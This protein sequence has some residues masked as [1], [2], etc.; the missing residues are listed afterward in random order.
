MATRGSERLLLQEAEGQSS[1][2]QHKSRSWTC[3]MD[4]VLEAFVLYCPAV[5]TFMCVVLALNKAQSDCQTS[6]D[7]KES[8]VQA[9]LARRQGLPL[10]YAD[11]QSKRDEDR[12]DGRLPE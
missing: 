1:H 9:P 10:I 11:I 6:P 12:V 4:T 3:S 2:K 7:C 8:S 5:C